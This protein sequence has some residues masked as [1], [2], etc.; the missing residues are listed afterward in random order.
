M[1]LLSSFPFENHVRTIEE[2]LVKGVG[3]PFR[4]LETLEIVPRLIQVHAKTLKATT[5]NAGWEELHNPPGQDLGFKKG[6]VRKLGKDYPEDL[7]DKGIGKWKPAICQYPAAPGKFHG[8]PPFHAP[9]LDDDNFAFKGGVERLAQ[10]LRQFLGE[11]FKL[12]AR[13]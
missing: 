5:M 1:V 11:D 8:H 10:R 3:N 9:A 12:V 2:V 6:I 4:D 7:M 13:A